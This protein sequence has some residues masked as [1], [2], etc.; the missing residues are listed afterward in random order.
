MIDDILAKVTVG[1]I[2]T[3]IDKATDVSGEALLWSGIHA[4][5]GN[6]PPNYDEI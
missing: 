3:I 4:P 2:L 1:S 6:P 5:L